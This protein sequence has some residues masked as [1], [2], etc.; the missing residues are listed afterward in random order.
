M[1][2]ISIAPASAANGTR[3]WLVAVALLVATFVVYLPVRN[4]GFVAYDD[5]EYVSDNVWVR[6]GLTWDGVT[7]AFTTGH[8]SNWHPLTWLSH[9]LDTELF[10]AAAAGP[11]LTNALFHAANAALLFICLHRLA[12]ALVCSAWVSAIFALHPLRVE[13][14]A[15]IAER[16]DVL[17]GFF[18]LLT[19]LAYAKYVAAPPSS[20][21]R[22]RWYAGAVLLFGLGLMSKPMLVTLPCVLLL[23]D[24]W[25]LRRLELSSLGESLRRAG[26]LLR[27]KIPF[28]VLS[29]FSSW[30]TF[31]VQAEGG[32][33]RSL[34]SFD[35]GARLANAL[36]SYGR[37]IEKTLWPAQLAVFYPHPGGWPA[38]WVAAAALV[39]AA[40][41]VA[42]LGMRRKKP[43]LMTGWCWFLGMLVPT[44]GLIQV[45][46]QAMADRYTYLPSI[47]LLIVFAWGVVAVFERWRLPLAALGVVGAA[48]VV[49]CAA[50]TRVQLAHWRDSETLFLRALAVTENNFVAHN[51]LGYAK[52]QSGD[53]D[54]AIVH[55]KKALEIHPAFAE[56]HTNL[57]NALLQRG[58]VDDAIACFRSA[59][60]AAPEF[61]LARYNLGTTLLGRGDVEGAIAEF[62][63]TARQRPDDALVHTNLG[64]ARLQKRQLPEAI[65]SHRR[66]LQL[67]PHN[68]DRHNNLGSA[69]VQAGNTEEGAAHFRK[70]LQIEP[71]HANAHFNLADLQLRL[72]RIDEAIEHFQETL[73]LQPDDADAHST[74]GAIFLQSGR[75]EEAE[76]HLRSAVKLR[77]GEVRATTQLA[78]ILATAAKSS[79]RNGRES[80]EL[81]EKANRLSGGNDAVVL[82]VLAAAHAEC[83]RFAEAA[84]I[85]RQAI[86]LARAQGNTGLVDNIAAQLKAYEAGAPHREGTAAEAAAGAARP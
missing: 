48:L 75:I 77:D 58:Q 72:G 33:V 51:G 84:T 81:A 24:V 19:L 73:E 43:F 5:P 66:A 6:S 49:S 44:I 29:A 53:V 17:S 36:V 8:A 13:S 67:Q 32:A 78:W 71:R 37:Y 85:A 38:W 64:N 31:A 40:A 74:L 68:P 18:F 63:I 14:V 86:S 57:G 21:F 10:G 62:E 30:A 52:L 7:W 47:G 59:L 55:F 50:A 82:H 27:E 12:G 69:L 25:P 42:A 83:G 45:G 54:H 9:M 76:T 4:H 1:S 20:R 16:K 56:A 80:F 60:A 46:N 26:P 34:G 79:L 15:W 23:I 2:E 70:A 28:F 41:S 11:H 35:F 3:V 65:V 22:A 39:L 61:A